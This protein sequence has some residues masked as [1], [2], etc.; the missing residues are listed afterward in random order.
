M[1]LRAISSS[2]RSLPLAPYT[3]LEAIP[4]FKSVYVDA[5]IHQRLLW[6]HL[7]FPTEGSYG[8]TL[9]LY[10]YKGFTVYWKNWKFQQI[11]CDCY[12]V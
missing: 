11:H 1:I 6:Q 4:G 8:P 3:G 10:K 5:W 9:I 12:I 7:K 2:S